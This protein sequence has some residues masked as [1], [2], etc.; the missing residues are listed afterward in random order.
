MRILIGTG[1]NFGPAEYQNIGDIAMLQV[2]LTR[3]AELWPDAEILVLTDSVTDLARFCPSAQPL[4][5]YGAETW[6]DGGVIE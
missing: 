2:A 5:R 4:S 3:L 1:L 6:I